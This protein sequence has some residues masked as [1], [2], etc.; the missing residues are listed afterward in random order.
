VR[1]APPPRISAETYTHR[2]MAKRRQLER[3]VAARKAAARAERRNR[4]QPE[5]RAS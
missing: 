2:A 1:E 4:R 5:D 3:E